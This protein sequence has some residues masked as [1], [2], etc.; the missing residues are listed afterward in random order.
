M[1]SQ[2]TAK[3]TRTDKVSIQTTIETEGINRTQGTTRGMGSR[4]GMTTTKIEIGLITEDDQTNINTTETNPEDRESL[5]TQ[6]K[7][8]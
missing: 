7:I 3:I 6:T 4:T 5:S 2:A 1:D 8:C